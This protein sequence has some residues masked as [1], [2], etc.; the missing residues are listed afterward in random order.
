MGVTVT[1]LF[2]LGAM[3]MRLFGSPLLH[4]SLQILSLISLIVGFAFGIKLAQMTEILYKFEG[5][6]HTICGTVV[7]GL[8]IIQPFLGLLHHNF[9]KKHQARSA[10]SHAHI[11]FGRMIMV[12]GV[13]NGG[14]GLRLAANT[15]NGEIAYGVVAGVMALAY[16]VLIVFKRKKTETR[17]MWNKERDGEVEMTSRS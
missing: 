1:L 15:K 14:L 12:L 2:P 13:I 10:I 9:Y 3:S 11:W 17:W 8:F 6:T 4:A 5:R 7:V 16:V